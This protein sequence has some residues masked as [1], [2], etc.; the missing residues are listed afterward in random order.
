MSV[1]SIADVA[2]HAGLS[3]MSV[4]RVLNDSPSVSTA[5]RERVLRAI[6]ELGY[7]PSAPARS[8]ARGR[9]Q[10]LGVLIPSTNN[11]I[12]G[13]YV[14]G[15]RDA[16]RQA[17]Y[18]VVLSK[19]AGDVDSA[20]ETDARLL[21]EQRA[22]GVIITYAGWHE[23]VF[24]LM[25]RGV[26]V[27]C[28]DHRVPGC[29]R[30]TLDNPDAMRQAVVHLVRLGHRAIGVITGPIHVASER[31]RLVGYRRAMR[32]HGLALE[33]PLQVIAPEFTDECGYAMA[34]DALT[35]A[36][37]PSALIVGSSTLIAGVLLATVEMGMQVPND[38]ALVGL[39]E[40]SWSRAYL[41]DYV[42]RGAGLSNGVRSLP[43]APQPT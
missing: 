35:R 9:T 3:A 32:E 14:D 25:R 8:L 20:K 27:V 24:W 7:M 43:P 16:A 5:T 39:G 6:A 36:G 31:E 22:A 4:S 1:V 26:Q 37:R 11:P 41:A 28:I 23:Q 40:L 13:L 2:V 15:I 29:D 38:L 10:L 19:P 12:Y 42:N 21:S 33:R 18:S 34:R 17:G 30:I